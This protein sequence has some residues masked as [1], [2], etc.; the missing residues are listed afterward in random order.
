V[1][2]LPNARR[3]PL[4]AA[5]LVASAYASVACGYSEEEMAT[6]QREIDALTT[7]VRSLRMANM[8]PVYGYAMPAASG[9]EPGAQGAPTEAE[10][11]EDAKTRR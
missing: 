11:Q 4:L 8:P 6:K 2:P 3:A 7:E 5:L 1:I 10:G 9:A